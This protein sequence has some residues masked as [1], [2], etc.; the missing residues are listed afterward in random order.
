M[1]CSGIDSALQP[2]LDTV[3]QEVSTSEQHEQ[4]G[5]TM[6]EGERTTVTYNIDMSD[7][8]TFSEQNSHEVSSIMCF[9]FERHLLYLD[10][11]A[12]IFFLVY[13]I[14]MII[15]DDWDILPTIVRK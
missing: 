14:G 12:K 9:N 13:G 1:C 5:E 10:Q 7:N 3:E 15:L 2:L 8:L 6:T 4:T 11:S